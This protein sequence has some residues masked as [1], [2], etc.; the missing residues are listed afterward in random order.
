M[1]LN[2][3]KVMT[4]NKQNPEGVRP[5][6]TMGFNPSDLLK[7]NKTL[8]G[9]DLLQRWVSTHLIWT[10]YNNGFQPIGLLPPKIKQLKKS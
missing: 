7:I 1:L 4:E 9:W 10:Y 6:T 8:K 3:V 5:T 2:L